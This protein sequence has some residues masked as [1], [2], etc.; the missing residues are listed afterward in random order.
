MPDNQKTSPGGGTAPKSGGNTPKPG[1]GK[2]SAKDGSRAQSRPG[3]GKAGQSKGGNAPRSGAKKSTVTK[4][5]G[6][7]GALL[8][9]GAVGLVVVII[10]V[11][12]IV[13][14]T[15]TTSTA[16]TPVTPATASL[17]STVTTI[18]QSMFDKVG[19]TTTVQINPPVIPPSGQPKLTLDGKPGALF[20][21]AEFC[22]YCAAERWA[23]VVALS[24]FGTFSGLQVT[25]SS[26]TDVAANTSTFSFR[27]AAYTSQYLTFQMVEQETNI[28]SGNSYKPLETIT[29][30]Q[31]AILNTYEQPPLDPNAQVGSFGYPFMDIGNQVLVT[32]PTFDPGILAG[33]SQSDIA[34]NLGDPTNPATQAIIASANYLSAAVCDITGQTPSTLCKSPGVSTASKALKL[35]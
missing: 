29:K 18:P 12:V 25:G 6:A 16:Y 28:P 33:M 22:P 2:K 30:A 15:S 14:A 21:G 24:R 13:K 26:H 8:A 23:I 20:V 3:S 7:S 35:S 9:W 1:A 4:P 19:V 34:G 32:S 31:Q 17:V 5:R 27:T 11:L 10:A